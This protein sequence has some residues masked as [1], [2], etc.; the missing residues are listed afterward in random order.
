MGS[1]PRPLTSGKFIASKILK[2]RC[3]QIPTGTPEKMAGSRLHN[4]PRR[5]SK[6]PSNP[7]SP[8]SREQLVE[9]L[10]TVN[11]DRPVDS[12][13]ADSSQGPQGLSSLDPEAP[14]NEA[15]PCV[16]RLSRHRRSEPRDSRSIVIWGVSPDTPLVT[17]RQRL[18]SEIGI[19]AERVKQITWKQCGEKR[20]VHIVYI[21][22]QARDNHFDA[23]S[24]TCRAHGW[25]ALK[26][27][28]YQTR[29][30]QR[31]LPPIL[32]GD[33]PSVIQGRP[34]EQ[35]QEEDANSSDLDA[36]GS[37]QPPPVP[38]ISEPRANLRRLA[39]LA[40]GS[41]NMGGDFDS[42]KAELEAYFLKMKYEIIA[43]QEVH[44]PQNVS[45]KGYKFFGADK[46]NRG[47][48]GGAAFLVA[49]HLAGIVE[50]V[51][52]DDTHNQVWIKVLGSSGT[53]DLYLCS[54]YMPQES[55]RRSEACEC[56]ELLQQRIA[57]YQELGVVVIAGDLNAKI[58]AHITPEDAREL[59]A[60][61]QG[62]TSPNGK[63]LCELLSTSRL[64]SLGGHKR[65]PADK[66]YWYMHS[67]HRGT[68]AID[69]ILV[70]HSHRN[71]SLPDFKVDYI[72]LGT[73]HHLLRAT[74]YCPRRVSRRK[75]DR[76]F[77]RFC[78]EK[79]KCQQVL[80]LLGAIPG[81]N[82]E[83][84]DPLSPTGKYQ[85]KL[86]DLFDEY[87]PAVIAAANLDP[88]AVA[89]D[90]ISKMEQA[91]EYSVGS[92]L[93]SK[94]YSRAWFDDE[95]KK[96]IIVRRISH[97]AWEKQR[98]AETWN[99][100]KQDKKVV[101]TLIKKKKKEVWF[102]LIDGITSDQRDNPKRM[103]ST[104]SK[105]TGRKSK[106]AGGS[107]L[108]SNGNL[109]VTP[110]EREATWTAHQRK[111]GRESAAPEFQENF[112][113]Q[114]EEE[115]DGY[116]QDSRSVEDD[117]NLDGLFT[118]E[119][120]A[121]GMDVLKL[122]KACGTD[123][124]RNEWMKAGGLP[125]MSALRK[126]FNW[127]IST[128]Q[129]PSDWASSLIVYLYKDGDERDPGN[130]RGI[131]LISCLGKLFLTLWNTRITHYLE[132]NNLLAE[133]Q[134]GFRA[135]RS[136]IDQ[137]FT[138]NTALLH[139]RREGKPT[140]L[141]FIDFSKAF[142]SVWHTGL[143]KKLY[144]LGIK[145]K[146]WRILRALY[147]NLEASVLVDGKPGQKVPQEQGV[148]QGDPLS[149]ILFSMFINEL[150][151]E[152]RR[153]GGNV[154]VSTKELFSLLYADDI[155]L[156][157]DTPAELQKMI[158]IVDNYTAKWRLTLNARK[159]KIMIVNPQRTDQ[160]VEPEEWTFRGRNL[161]I[162]QE[163]KYLGVWF[164]NNLTWKKHVE[165]VTAKG[166]ALLP[167]LRQFFSQQRIPLMIKRLVHTALVRSPLEYASAIWSCNK[168]EEDKLESIQHTVAVWMLRT[169][170]KACKFGLR[171]ILGLPSLKTRRVMLRLF[172]VAKL[173]RM[174][175]ERLA[176]HCYKTPAPTRNTLRG[177][178]QKPWFAIV[179]P[180]FTT[181]GQTLHIPYGKLSLGHVMEPKVPQGYIGRL[182][183]GFDDVTLA[184]RTHVRYN[185][186]VVERAALCQAF[187]DYST[188]EMVEMIHGDKLGAVHSLVRRKPSH[189]NWRR[190]RLLCGT[191]AL[192]Q[193]R[194]RI[195]RY[196]THE[197]AS[198]PLCGQAP[199]SPVHFLR[200]CTNQFMVR[201]RTS[202]DAEMEQG[203]VFASLSTKA[204]AAFMLGC[205]VKAP[206]NEAL[207]PSNSEDALSEDFVAVCYRYRSEQLSIINA[208]VDG[209]SDN[210]ENAVGSDDGADDEGISVHVA[211]QTPAVA[212][213]GE[214]EDRDVD[215]NIEELAAAGVEGDN[216]VDVVNI[217]A[218]GEIDNRI[219]GVFGSPEGVGKTLRGLIQ[220]YIYQHFNVVAR[221][222]RGVVV[223]GDR[224][225]ADHAYH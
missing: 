46:E 120:V 175:T 121:T 222:A 81:E 194:E 159:S 4:R 10:V 151:E 193:T 145:G 208:A 137:E 109:A 196:T 58:G 136:T 165:Y 157:A 93:I 200:E 3:G 87:D 62:Q 28:P 29:V 35:P 140:Y 82:N 52:V 202:H 164:T 135:G 48:S 173:A 201:A 68:S 9:Q 116:A 31:N 70:P 188:L 104:I 24:V 153:A 144:E 112:R 118:D 171:A 205:T 179:K 86:T 74:V 122:H 84:L 13:E 83:V 141:F 108:K 163:Y 15:T 1:L 176:Y 88:Q 39:T 18:S 94:K 113:Q 91:L 17:V 66:S 149:P 127:V 26:S 178:T 19:Y 64:I 101:K 132:S 155:V 56:W 11:D 125:L 38:R 211:V 60:Y 96:A 90:F 20:L 45:I 220:P 103:W 110:E 61:W 191:S 204:Q 190:I 14:G 197:S 138:L 16:W 27:R 12:G 105:I 73:D 49:H 78:A 180:W 167:P 119:D 219:N 40:L 187:R 67:F 33:E 115:V 6:S 130:H 189:A 131:S 152:L 225:I 129:I 79:L 92:K 128:E 203:S 150:V 224:M 206:N 212:R 169:N 71:R 158:D 172:Y 111:L 221:P 174:D 185:A 44:N 21:C 37:P 32:L 216:E 100:Y 41:L 214:S 99:K 95:V 106:K 182:D 218:H 126:L 80:P 55:R 124:V 209:E 213:I 97:A 114:T 85:Q 215:G 2:N 217:A 160:A 156:M 77:R 210:D 42:K 63:L 54:A 183:T 143:W 107:V 146:A 186:Q 57:E 147:A 207:T 89:R 148:R 123:Q 65:P 22:T 69:H 195:T 76:K 117:V 72:N 168:P 75:P 181:P 7:V 8:I 59:G 184:W 50:R 223:H 192:N 162:V 134:G 198:C 166:K 98:G 177:S 161:E 51:Q 170:K 154:R 133:E 139:R 102:N 43:L 199:E 23:M 34:P 36:P 53:E 47:S 5:S 142:D 30:L 25:K